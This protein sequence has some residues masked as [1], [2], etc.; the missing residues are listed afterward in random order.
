MPW[1]TIALGS[2]R[3]GSQASPARVSTPFGLSARGHKNTGAAHGVRGGGGWPHPA[4]ASS[5]VGEER[6]LEHAGEAVSCIWGTEVEEAHRKHS[7]MSVAGQRR[8]TG[9][10]GSDE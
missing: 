8:G 3:H 10:A 1:D 2:P 6:L 7:P 5:K 9:S 4:A